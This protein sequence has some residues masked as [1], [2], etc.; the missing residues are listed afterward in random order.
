MGAS[1]EVGSALHLAASCGDRA[2]AELLLAAR[3]SPFLNHHGATPLDAAAS[4]GD[5]GLCRRFEALGLFAAHVYEKMPPGLIDSA[6]GRERWERRYV[7]VVP[8]YSATPA[9]SRGVLCALQLRVSRRDSDAAPS[10]AH[11]VH[12]ACAVPAACGAVVMVNIVDSAS[13]SPPGQRSVFFSCT[14]PGG[15]FTLLFR[16]A[17]A[18]LTARY[19][20]NSVSAGGWR[21]GCGGSAAE[22]SAGCLHQPH[23]AARSAACG[24]GAPLLC[25]R[26]RCGAGPTRIIVPDATQQRPDAH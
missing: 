15:A 25:S 19:P 2:S 21:C 16:P 7:T 10:E 6:L 17:C 20:S 12:S 3:A 22:R 26:R 8:R 13:I 18:V 4:A 1:R 5:V 24:S 9:P 14:P 11:L 23:A